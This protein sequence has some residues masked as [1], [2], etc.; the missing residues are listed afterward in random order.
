MRVAVLSSGNC[1]GYANRYSV[2]DTAPEHGPCECT[3]CA[4]AATGQPRTVQSMA[5]GHGPRSL[6]TFPLPMGTGPRQS[7]RAPADGILMFMKQKVYIETSI[8]TCLTG[9][10]SRDLIA[11]ARQE[12]TQCW[13]EHAAPLFELV[14][15]QSTI[16]EAEEHNWATSEIVSKLR[17]L[18]QNEATLSLSNRLVESGLILESAREDAMHIAIGAAYNCDYLLTWKFESIASVDRRRRIDS[19]VEKAGFACPAIC[20]PPQLHGGV[21]LCSDPIIEEVWRI[22]E[23][24][25]RDYNYD[26]GAMAEHIHEKSRWFAGERITLAPRPLEQRAVAQENADDYGKR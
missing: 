21:P 25:A 14:T 8:I 16:R 9:R 20:T 24:H 15:S 17:R 5:L 1:T 11:A 23:S 26:I 3:E 6:T 4:W 18:A 13:W 7:L 2:R 10:P 19:I 12:L 22:R